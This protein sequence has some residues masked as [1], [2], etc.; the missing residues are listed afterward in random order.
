M[1]RIAKSGFMIGILLFI[2]QYPSAI[3]QEETSN[4]QME[5]R[6]RSISIFPI[7]MYDSDIGFGFGGKSIIKNQLRYNESYD[8]TLFGS[9]KGEQ[10]YAFTFSI[11][12]FEIRH[13]T[14]YPV[15]FD[16]K[17]EYDKILK[18][19]FFGLGNNSKNNDWQ[20]PREFMKIEFILGHAF[21]EHIFGETSLS[22]N[23]TSVYDYE[24]INPLM[25]PDV[26]GTGKK[27]T[28][29]LT[30]R[31]CLDTRDS[32][33]NP[34]KGWKLSFDSDCAAKLI[35]GDY[36]FQRYRLEVSKYQGLF[37]PAHTWAVRLW[38]E[39]VEG[40]APYYEQCIIGG[41]WT[42]RGFKADRFIDRALTLVSNEYRFPIYG[43]L[44][45]VLLADA[46]RVYS[47][48]GKINLHNWKTSWGGGLR[49]YVTNFVTRLDV[50]TSKEGT[51]IFFN[52]GHVY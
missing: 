1:R 48:I 44:G 8:L 3:A 18:S 19:N 13:G 49:Y 5:T 30:A 26:A 47:S 10:W 9:T 50:G 31:L 39:H 43:K 35:G 6:R 45:G 38:T 7:L 28:S 16:V 15:A 23:H 40:T 42:A 52:F 29:Y 20:F 32:Q 17:L 21:T 34:H 2:L 24:D 36:N 12:D 22:Y 25:T 51:R 11:P 27:L 14:R 37:T 41:G 46:G 33:I 4:R